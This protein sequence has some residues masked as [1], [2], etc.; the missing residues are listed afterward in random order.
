M[1]AGVVAFPASNCKPT[2]TIAATT[3][4]T[5]VCARREAMNLVTVA[6]S[7]LAIPLRDRKPILGRPVNPQRHKSPQREEDESASDPPV[8]HRITWSKSADAQSYETRAVIMA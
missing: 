8:R 7:R 1:A 3:S 2:T 4:A 5:R 6:H